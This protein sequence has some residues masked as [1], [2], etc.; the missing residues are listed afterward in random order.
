MRNPETLAAVDR[1]MG[2]GTSTVIGRPTVNVG[3][4]NGGLKVNMIPEECNFEVDIRLPIGLVA[5]QVMAVINSLIPNYP[6]ATIELRKQEAASNPSSFSSIDHAMI[7]HLM[8][9]VELLGDSSPAIIPSMG[10]TDCKHY[11]Y[12]GVPAYVYG[13]SPVS[14]KFGQFIGTWLELRS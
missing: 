9:N 6:D 14:S 2:P 11:R 1:A 13:C 4:I 3:T 10:A 7:G 8:K 5:D 12:A